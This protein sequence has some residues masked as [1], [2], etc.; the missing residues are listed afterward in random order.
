MNMPKTILIADEKI[1]IRNLV[2]E[3]LEAEGF[4]VIAANDGREALY[5]A[6]QEKPDLI[7][8]DI[9]MPEMS[10]YDFIKIYRRERNTPKRRCL[11]DCTVLF[12]KR[13]SQIWLCPGRLPGVSGS[14]TARK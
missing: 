6:R 12:N 9:L 8:L 1:N 5:S 7:L 10:G 3:Y 11:H 2:R 13:N 4:R 14:N